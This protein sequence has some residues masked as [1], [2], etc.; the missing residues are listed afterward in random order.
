LWATAARPIAPAAKRCQEHHARAAAPCWNYFVVAAVALFLR[1]QHLHA[2]FDC[3]CTLPARAP[4]SPLPAR[5]IKQLSKLIGENAAAAIKEQ[6]MGDF[7]GRK[8][9]IDASMA[10][11]QFLVAVRSSDGSGPSQQLMNA[12]GEI[13]RCGA[14][15][16]GNRT[17]ASAHSAG[18]F[19]NTQSPTLYLYSAA[20]AAATSRACG[21]AR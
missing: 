2:L 13:T 10:I 21:T 15:I 4:C 14:Q 7:N 17:A 8:V 1:V 16:R 9:A 18:S 11:Y 5:S 12:A 19:N 20:H 3:P 6:A